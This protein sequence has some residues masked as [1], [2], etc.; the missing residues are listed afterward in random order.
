MGLRPGSYDSRDFNKEQL[1]ILSEARKSF[2]NTAST[3][4]GYVNSN[5]TAGR[6]QLYTKK[7][8]GL[9]KTKSEF[10]GDLFF[11]ESDDNFVIACAFYT[12][13]KRPLPSRLLWSAIRDLRES[14]RYYNLEEKLGK[15]IIIGAERIENT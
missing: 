2:R 15:K 8:I 11:S 4:F 5:G 12:T 9:F 3:D 1:K 14:V 13:E 7:R 6:T 10:V